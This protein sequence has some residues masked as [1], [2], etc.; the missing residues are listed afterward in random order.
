MPV[1]PIDSGFLAFPLSYFALTQYFRLIYRRDAQ[2]VRLC[3]LLNGNVA[4]NKKRQD[5]RIVRLYNNGKTEGEVIPVRLLFYVSKIARA[6]R[7]TF[8]NNSFSPLVTGSLAFDFIMKISGRFAERAFDNAGFSVAFV[9]PDLQRMWGGCAGNI[10][11]GLNLLEETP[12]LMATVGEDF[13]PYRQ[14][15]NSVG[16]ETTYVKTIAGTLTAQ[17]FIAEDDD[18]SQII[19][20]HPGAT[21]QA[22]QQ[23]INDL[24]SLPPLAIVAPNGKESML[25][26]GRELATAKTPFIFDPGQAIRMLN[27]TELEEMAALCKAVIFNHDEY[28]AFVEITGAPPRLSDTQAVIITRGEEGSETRCGGRVYQTAAAIFGDA[29]DTT[30]C[31]D[32]YRVGLIYGMLREW[33]WAQITGFASVLAGIKALRQ[34]GQGWTA[35]ADEVH[36]KCRRLFG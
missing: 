29:V 23:S 35:T 21:G 14:Y 1:F 13:T 5:A 10:A 4:L 2:F 33:K 34:G 30:G 24:S 22:H 27:K 36:D 15:L 7:I 17:A 16:I 6:G 9:T 26:F 32:A 11:Y 12:Q 25:R 3:C 31:G 28:N 18:N 8:M 20:F 19:I